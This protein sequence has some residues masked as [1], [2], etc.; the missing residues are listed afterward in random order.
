MVVVIG[1]GA[2]GL[3]AALKASEQTKVVVLEKND[4]AGKKL[5]LTGNGRCNYWHDNITSEYYET[6]NETNLKKILTRCDDTYD[7]LYSLGIY[8][9]IKDG[10]YYPY[11]MQAYSFREVLMQ[12]IEKK[13]IEIIYNAK[14]QSIEKDSDEFIIRYNDT[15][16]KASKVIVAAGSK[17]YPKT[18]SSGDS[19]ELVE[20]LGHEVSKIYPAL[21]SLKCEGDFLKIWSG[22][23]VDAKVQILVDGKIMKED[24]GEVQLTDYGISGLCVFNVSH[25]ASKNMDKKVRV[26]LNF[27]P[28]LKE[29]FISFLEKRSNMLKT[30]NISELLES[31]FSYKLINI[32]LHKAN[33]NKDAYFK[34]LTIKEKELLSKVVTSFD[35]EVIG[36]SSFEK[37]QVCAGGVSLKEINPLT[38]ESHLVKGLYI[39]GE[40]LDVNGICGGYNLA[41][42][43]T[44]GFIAGEN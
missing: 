25:I 3:I 22:I 13:N 33:I 40:A 5:L 39:V 18:G 24:I 17:A 32:F 38:M 35:L 19:Y 14:V 30:A 31:L 23:R 6:D 28:Y 4:K 8:P 20:A 2:S 10:Y 37:A 43:F 27:M 1:A 15:F 16:I 26:T 44:S 41:F 9:K 7:Y 21:T 11:S 12:N 34:S 29:N 36:V 42:A